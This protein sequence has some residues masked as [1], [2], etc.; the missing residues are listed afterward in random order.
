MSASAS[1]SVPP[2]RSTRPRA[3]AR[4]RP[5]PREPGRRTPRSKMLSRSSGSTPGPSS[6]T[7]TRTVA[8]SRTASIRAGA[9]CAWR[10]AFTSRMLR[11]SMRSSPVPR[12]RHPVGVHAT[13]CPAVRRPRTRVPMTASRSTSSL[14]ASV[15]RVAGGATRRRSRSISSTTS[16]SIRRSDSSGSSE[17]CSVSRCS[18]PDSPARP[19]RTAWSA[20]SQ[21]AT[22]RERDGSSNIAVD[23]EAPDLGRTDPARTAGL[24]PP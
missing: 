23:G 1:V 15:Q 4:P 13:S 8:S 2:A 3:M 6:L 9:P 12:T 5:C 14:G 18:A 11:T 22:V 24:S 17:R 10:E 16:V 21:S 7:R 19:D 20:S